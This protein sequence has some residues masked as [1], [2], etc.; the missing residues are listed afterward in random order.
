MFL[1]SEKTK[2]DKQTDTVITRSIFFSLSLFSPH[3][4]R[5]HIAHL[6][7]VSN[8]IRTAKELYEQ[9]LQE[10]QLPILL[11]ADIY[12][13]LG[14]DPLSFFSLFSPLFFQVTQ[15]PFYS[16]FFFME[17]NVILKSFVVVHCFERMQAGCTIALSH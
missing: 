5:F 15:F 10:K 3:L 13:Q 11:K 17:G 12:R 14:T 6:Y 16:F 1:D 2:K 4:V 9:L 7:E 8:R